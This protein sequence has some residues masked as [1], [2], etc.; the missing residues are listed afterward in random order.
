M[1]TLASLLVANDGWYIILCS[2][3]H[4][5]IVCG[6][7]TMARFKLKQTILLMIPQGY[8]G[9]SMQER[10]CT[11]IFYSHLLLYTI[12]NMLQIVYMSL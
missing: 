6:H 11:Y 5:G 3:N 2:T 12:H 4:F 9:K 10:V 7:A 8:V 1:A